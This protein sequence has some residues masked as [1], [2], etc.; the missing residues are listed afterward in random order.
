MS[1]V[2]V[3]QLMTF[4]IAC[5]AETFRTF[6]ARIQFQLV[7]FVPKQMLPQRTAAAKSLPT[8]V[9]FQPGTFV[10]RL[11]QMRLELVSRRETRRTVLARIGLCAGVNT[12]VMRQI[13]V[14]LEQL[15][16]VVTLKRSPVAVYGNF[17]L[18]QFAR[19]AE[20]FPAQR[21][22]VQLKLFIDRVYLHVTVQVRR[23]RKHL[24]A[25]VALVRLLSAVNST[26][27]RQVSGLRES[28][29]ADAAFERFLSG[30]NSPVRRQRLAVVTILSAFRA[31]VFTIVNV[32]MYPQ[33]TLYRK[34]LLAQSTRIRIS[35]NV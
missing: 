6:I 3:Y 28:F 33:V 22:S 8:D 23:A 17:V 16:A 34:L 21:A 9:T 13:P 10:V 26:V 5:S 30:M 32:H 19:V 12:D 7:T 24:L 1:V 27:R 4:Q 11:Q 14:R 15:S 31:L 25:L 29:A 18:L 20:T 2:C 35:D